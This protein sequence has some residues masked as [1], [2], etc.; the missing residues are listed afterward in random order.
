MKETEAK[1]YEVGF[2]II[3]SLTEEKVKEEY[4][5]IKNLILA[6]EDSEL[7]SEGLPQPKNLSYPISKTYKAEK[8]TY[9]R[10]YF[11]WIK[12]SANP[13]Q[14]VDIKK[15]LDDRELVLRYLII[16]TVRENTLVGGIEDSGTKSD[17]A[18]EEKKEIN[19]ENLKSIDES[20]D[21]LVLQ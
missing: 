7:I 20:I 2:H 17:K 1:I 4:D 18:T 3:P 8:N 10:A 11:S 19:E 15:E 12:F 14:I 5:S 9:S 21:E 6:R 13:E 16:N